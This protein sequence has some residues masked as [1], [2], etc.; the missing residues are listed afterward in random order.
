MKAQMFLVTGSRDWRDKTKLVDA[1]D[2]ALAFNPNMRLI[3][4]GAAGADRLAHDWAKERGVPVQSFA[5]DYSRPSPQR[6]HERNDR[7]LAL[8]DQVVAFWDGESR[9]TKSVI[10]KA[11]QRGLRLQVV[12]CPSLF[13]GDQENAA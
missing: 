2:L 1:L 9:G 5:P 12:R 13:A 6:Y 3:H 7:M 8:A 4:G 11:R 10:D